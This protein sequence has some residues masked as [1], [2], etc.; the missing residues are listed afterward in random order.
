MPAVAVDYLLQPYHADVESAPV[1][2]RL[3]NTQFVRSEAGRFHLHQTDRD[4]A[5]SRMAA[6]QPEDRQTQPPPFSLYALRHRAAEYFKE[7]RK[8]RETWKTLDDLAPQLAEFEVRIAGE[9]YDAAAAVLLDIDF[10]YLIQWGHAQLVAQLHERLRGHLADRTCVVK[11]LWNLGS[12]YVFLGRYDR[13]IDCFDN[14]LVAKPEIGERQGKGVV[15]HGLGLCHRNLGDYLGAIGH[16]QQFLSI[17]RDIGDRGGQGAALGDLGKCY[18]CLG[19]YDR[20]LDHLQ[21]YLAIAQET[22]EDNSEGAA[23]DNLGLCHRS[24]G[25]HLRAIDHFERSLAV[26]R[27]ISNRYGEGAV[28]VNLGDAY[29]ELGELASAREC[30]QDACKIADETGNRQNQ[31]G[32]R[33]GLALTRLYESNLDAACEAIDGARSYDNPTNTAAAWMTT[34]IIRL[35]QGEPEAAREAFASAVTEADRLLALC[36]QNF[37]ALDT[38]GLAL[39]G[40]ALCDV[41]GHLAAAEA[42]FAAA[43]QITQAK[44]VV[45]ALLNQFDALALADTSGILAPVRRTAA[46]A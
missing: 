33:F 42:A 16:F 3:V 32:A 7:T 10:N 41:R 23:L 11:S 43:R 35:R 29:R 27:K 13:A 14:C 30:F 39:C 8:P 6:G 4:Y 40:L 17:A 21:Q 31:H 36:G 1:L 37:A 26:T 24:L 15:F 20:A 38:K 22:V 2:R 19:D 12:C 44:G 18:S 28:L 9:D 5:L 45:T 25:D 34:G 46:G